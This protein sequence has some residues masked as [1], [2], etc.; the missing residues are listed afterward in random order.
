M[1]HGGIAWSVAARP[2]RGITSGVTGCGQTHSVPDAQDMPIAH[3]DGQW[4]Y[5]GTGVV[6]VAVVDVRSVAWYTAS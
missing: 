2:R 6:V 1:S 4:V 5:S 3:D